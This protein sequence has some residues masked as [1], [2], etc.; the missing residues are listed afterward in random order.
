MHHKLL[1]TLV[2][3]GAVAQGIR[4]ENAEVKYYTRTWNVDSKS[5]ESTQ[6][7]ITE[8]IPTQREPQILSVAWGSS[9]GMTINACRAYFVLNGL[10]AGEKAFEDSGS[11]LIKAIALNFDEEPDVNGISTI[12][13]NAAHA[14]DAWFTLDG[15]RL[16][17]APQL[18]GLYI[19]NGRKVYLNGVNKCMNQILHY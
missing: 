10:T 3:L 15:R 11:N 7:T 16:L 13:A 12:S 1:L 18:P 5:V 9:E 2:L 8:Y 4:A 6:V 14:S 17:E 19:H